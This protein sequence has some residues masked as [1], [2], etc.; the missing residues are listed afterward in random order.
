MSVQNHLVQQRMLE[1]EKMISAGNQRNQE[2]GEAMH[3]M[4]MQTLQQV[5]QGLTQVIGAIVSAVLSG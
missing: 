2:F 3:Q 1:I 5:L 4:A